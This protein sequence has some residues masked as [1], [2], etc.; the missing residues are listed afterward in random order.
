MGSVTTTS[1]PQSEYWSMRLRLLLED[2]GPAG[3]VLGDGAAHLR[4]GVPGVDGAQ[5]GQ[6]RSAGV[7]QQPVGVS[8]VNGVDVDPVDW[9]RRPEPGDLGEHAVCAGGRME[10]PGGYQLPL[11]GDV[12]VV[13]VAVLV[14]R[15]PA[16]DQALPGGPGHDVVLGAAVGAVTVRRLQHQPVLHPVVRAFAG[17]MARVVEVSEPVDGE[18]NGARFVCV[19]TG[20]LVDDD[21]VQVGLVVPAAPGR[22]TRRGWRNRRGARPL[23]PGRGRWRL[24]RDLRS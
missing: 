23:G 15:F 14:V 21:D 3:V 16:E 18:S 24:G 10:A 22:G 1:H 5:D 11:V 8:S 6:E 19:I 12:A 9:T 2:V 7:P 13:A 20:R 4:H 17:E